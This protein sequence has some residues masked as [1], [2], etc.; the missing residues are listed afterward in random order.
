[1]SLAKL[2]H[3]KLKAGEFKDVIKLLRDNKNEAL[4]HM[5]SMDIVSILVDNL[6]EENLRDDFKLFSTC[7]NL[8]K[9]IAEKCVPQEV[10]F[11][12]LQRVELT[13]NDEIFTSLL[14]VLQVV[15]LRLNENKARSLEWSMNSIFSYI[16]AIGLPDYM[17]NIGSEEEKLLECD[18]T[19]R[20]IL[21]LYMT[22]ILF[23]EPIVKAFHKEKNNIFE[24]TGITR[25]NVV[26]S[27]ILQLMG[28][29]LV[30]LN[31]HHPTSRVYEDSILAKAGERFR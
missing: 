28:K 15:L 26:I 3:A 31:L 22:V 21:Q 6:T 10:L 18:E 25:K 14:K 16:E 11:E 23:L 12:L 5:E 19:I 13:K 4:L 20:R 7:E 9:L 29:P 1:M 30:Y 24:V 2:V 17:T 8:L 27:F